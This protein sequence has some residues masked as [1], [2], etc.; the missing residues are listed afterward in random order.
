M[1]RSCAVIRTPSTVKQAQPGSS[2]ATIPDN[3]GR[4]HDRYTMSA[5]HGSA[6][7]R[8]RDGLTHRHCVS[9]NVALILV[10]E[11]GIATDHVIHDVIYCFGPVFPT[12]PFAAFG[13]HAHSPVRQHS[14]SSSWRHLSPTHSIT[15]WLGGFR[16]RLR[17]RR[18]GTLPLLPVM[19]I[20]FTTLFV[21]QVE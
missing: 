21:P 11:L 14:L 9:G 8:M 1:P 7:S 16:G 4:I 18:E 12:A 6:R 10:Q 17:L 19:M 5:R 2:Y 20:L 15:I 3:T 13:G